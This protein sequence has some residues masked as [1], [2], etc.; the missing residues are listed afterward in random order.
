[1]TSFFIRLPPGTKLLTSNQRYHWRTRAKITRELR[2]M[3]RD[4]AE[5]Q[6]IPRADKVHVRGHWHYHDNRKRDPG[7]WYPSL[8]AMIDGALVDSGIITDDDDKHLIFDG[9][10]RG[11]PNIRHG[12]L[13]LEIEVDGD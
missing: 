13:V 3:S 5:Q 7:N 9:I 4:L 11:E 1:V 8:K 10:H 2:T 6:E 12:Q